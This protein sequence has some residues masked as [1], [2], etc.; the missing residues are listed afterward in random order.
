[1]HGG[2]ETWVLDPFSLVKEAPV[3]I[4]PDGALS[5]TTLGWGKPKEVGVVARSHRLVRTTAA[6]G[7]LDGRY[8][9]AYTSNVSNCF[10]A[11]VMTASPAPS[12]TAMFDGI[13][14]RYDLLNRVLSG[15]VD[16]RWRKRVVA[17]ALRGPAGARLDACA[18]TLDLSAMLADAS[19][20]ERVVA[21][22]LAA[23]MLRHGRHKAPAVETVVGDACALPFPASTFASAVCGFGVR[24]VS[25]AEAFARESLRVLV[26]GGRL[27][28]LEA[29]RPERVVGI[30]L[31]RTYVRY[32]F[33][34]LGAVV[35]R[36]RGAYEYFVRSV[37]G[38]STRSA[39][40]QL[41]RRVG[42]TNVHGYDVTL[43]LAGIVVAEV[44]R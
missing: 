20:H 36:N 42:F 30:V 35:S 16:Q 8:V 21:V 5:G 13:A 28:V 1:V 37:R 25:S 44:P 43:G 10:E 33:P 26:P 29:F 41:L 3:C 23:E 19:P 40:Q 11:S 24:N 22:D 14:P 27:V 6:P 32:V 39:F 18:G 17:E 34:A 12:T 38:F 7:R 9:G 15:G 31:H 4:E 2:L